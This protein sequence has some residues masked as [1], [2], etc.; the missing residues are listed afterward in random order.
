MVWVHEFSLNL[1]GFSVK[2]RSACDLIHKP[3]GRLLT[4]VQTQIGTSWFITASRP[5]PHSPVTRSSIGLQGINAATDV[6]CLLFVCRRTD[7]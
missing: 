5:A 6:P 7:A 3:E 4:S 2:T 1:L